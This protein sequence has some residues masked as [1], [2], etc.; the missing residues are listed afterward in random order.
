[1]PQQIHVACAGWNI[2]KQA[3]ASFPRCGGHL[4]RY[5]SLLDA[6][7]INS[8]FYRP[9]CYMTY[10]RWARTVPDAFRFAVKAPKQ[11]THGLRLAHSASALDAF[12]PQLNALGEKLGPILFQ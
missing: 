5:A 1:M 12:L 7:E 6:V 9:H 10:E 2:P 11:I 3:A 4:E 8:S